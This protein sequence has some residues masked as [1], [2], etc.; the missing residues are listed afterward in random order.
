MLA[1]LVQPTLKGEDI[2]TTVCLSPGAPSPSMMETDTLELCL[3]IDIPVG[4]LVG[5]L[6]ID[7][8]NAV[9]REREREAAK[10]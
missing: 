3:L 8:M 7:I 5:R 9:T 6:L 4:D 1:P 10:Q 2:R